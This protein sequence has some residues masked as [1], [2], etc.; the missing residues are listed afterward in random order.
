M[1][2]SLPLQEPDTVCTAPSASVASSSNSHQPQPAA[3]G[4]ADGPKS[5]VSPEPPVI[6][7]ALEAILKATEVTYLEEELEVFREATDL[8]INEARHMEQLDETAKQALASEWEESRLKQ[9][10]VPH[11]VTQQ[12]LVVEELHDELLHRQ[13]R[14]A[15]SLVT[16]DHNQSNAAQP[17]V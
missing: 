2:P 15:P 8:L 16:P 11:S 6:D 13:H 14:G 4:K 3:C 9:E 5:E 1:T 10:V 12:Q 7:P 17:Q